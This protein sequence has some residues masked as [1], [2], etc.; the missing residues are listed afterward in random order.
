MRSRSCFCRNFVTTSGPNVNDTPRSFSPQPIT[1]LSGSDHSKSH[2]RPWSG[3]SVGRIIRRTCSID[4]RSGLSP[5]TTTT[6]TSTTS[7]RHSTTTHSCTHTSRTHAL[8]AYL[9]V[10][11]V[12]LRRHAAA[13]DLGVDPKTR[14]Q[15]TYVFQVTWGQFVSSKLTP[16]QI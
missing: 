3:T 11:C 4:C 16:S 13:L 1:S 9:A 12:A 15:L 8:C 14:P 6:T 5:A 2:S 10:R 7:R